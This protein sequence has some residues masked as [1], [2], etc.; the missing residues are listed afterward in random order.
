MWLCSRQARTSLFVF[1]LFRKWR[2]ERQYTLGGIYLVH[3]G[4]EPALFSPC[5]LALVEQQQ[6]GARVCVLGGGRGEGGE[7]EKVESGTRDRD[8]KVICSANKKIS[9]VVGFN[10]FAVCLRNLES[11]VMRAPLTRPGK[12]MAPSADH[13][14]WPSL[15]SR[16]SLRRDLCWQAWLF[17]RLCDLPTLV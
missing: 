6:G 17:V 9:K 1:C 15:L 13:I 14:G 4:A 2:E 11:H 5:L 3:C 16:T 10:L 7:E 12:N 8:P